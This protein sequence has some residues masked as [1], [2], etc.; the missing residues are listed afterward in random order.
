MTEQ[1]VLYGDCR[2]VLKTLETHSIALCL[3]DPPYKVTNWASGFGTSGL[4]YGGIEPPEFKDWLW[5]VKR[6]LKEDGQ[7]VIFESTYN[8]HKLYNVLEVLGFRVAQTGVWF[9]TNRTNFI[10]GPMYR[11]HMDVWVWAVKPHKGEKY[12]FH[13]D[14]GREPM[15]DVYVAPNIRTLGERVPGIKPLDLIERF[16]VVHTEPGDWVLDPFLG[17]GTTLLACR[18]TG[19]NGIGIELRTELKADINRRILNNV[20]LELWKGRSEGT[21]GGRKATGKTTTGLGKKDV[22][23]VVES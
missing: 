11:N 12:T 17:S 6:V 22:G 21:A 9:V 3:T 14:R 23:T 5:E 16:I 18:R 15:S 8:L 13:Y 2:E 1:R 4:T 7:V 20:G 10:K 19:R